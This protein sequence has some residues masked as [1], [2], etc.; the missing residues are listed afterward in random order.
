MIAGRALRLILP[1][2]VAILVAAA[3]ASAQ[4]NVPADTAAPRDTTTAPLPPVTPAAPVV[5]DTI[6]VPPLSPDTLLADTLAPDT[7]SGE[8]VPP[9]D[10]EA[11]AV[12]AELRR[13]PGYVATEY[14]ADSAIYRTE[15]GVLRLIGQAQV[16]REGQRINADSIVYRDQQGLVEAYGE[17]KVTGQAEELTGEVLY[18]DIATRRASALKA[19]TQ[20]TQN[21]TWFVT[22]D[23]TVEGTTR[24]FATDGHF[25]TCDLEIPH[26]H[27]EADRIKIVK[28]RY[29]VGRPARL[30]FG[31]VPVMVLPFFLQSLQQGRRSGFVVPRFSMTDIVRNSG[32]TREITNLGWY[33]AVNEYLGAELTGTWRSGAY[34]GLRGNVDFRWRRQFLDGNLGIER[35]WRQSGRR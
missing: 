1:T 4:G 31:R 14:L 15:E 29:L 9:P 6:P 2:A 21:A 17:P 28:D 19:K 24:I 35:Y 33:W 12:M 3:G 8:R 16:E 23:V 18:Y 22:G 25:T 26:Y 32:H 5:G 7:A 20:V 13:L 10:P 30:Y 11:D 27:F 34:T